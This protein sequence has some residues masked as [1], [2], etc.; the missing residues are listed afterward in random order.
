MKWE[1]PVNRTYAIA[2]VLTKVMY[3]SMTASAVMF[4]FLL[5]LTRL[6]P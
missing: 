2:D 5:L 1:A 3:F 6:H 4:V